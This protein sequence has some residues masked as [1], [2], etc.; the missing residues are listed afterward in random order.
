MRF[1]LY[2]D[3][4]LARDIPEHGLCRGDVVKIVDYHPS[5]NSENGYS[6]EVFNALGGTIAVTAVLESELE[7]L[8]KDEV[9]SVRPLTR[10][11]F[12]S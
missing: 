8:H 7:S 2:T 3:A 9:L 5:L 6:I 4:A 12:R 1:D 10:E 11:S